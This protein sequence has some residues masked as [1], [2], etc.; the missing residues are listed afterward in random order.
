MGK[1]FGLES[2]RNFGILR[3]DLGGNLAFPVLEPNRNLQV[4]EL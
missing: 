1:R 4:V 2:A 3:A